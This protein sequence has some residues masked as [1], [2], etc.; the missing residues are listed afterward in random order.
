MSISSKNK[1]EKL[2]DLEIMELSKSMP[3]SVKK[4]IFQNFAK[5]ESE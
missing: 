2:D 3:K 5:E 1:E 4:D